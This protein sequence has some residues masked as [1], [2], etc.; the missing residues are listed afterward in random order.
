MVKSVHLIVCFT[1]Y[2]LFHVYYMSKIYSLLKSVH[3]CCTQSKTNAD[4]KE[5][6]FPLKGD[7]TNLVPQP[8]DAAGR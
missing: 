1:Y 4:V 7:S 3:V 5:P 8:I 2:F 6:T